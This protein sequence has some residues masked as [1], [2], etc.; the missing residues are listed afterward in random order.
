MDLDEETIW[1]IQVAAIYEQVGM[2]AEV[3]ALLSAILVFE[4]LVIYEEKHQKILLYMV[5]TI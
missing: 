4:Y 1:C 5:S 2:K 3:C